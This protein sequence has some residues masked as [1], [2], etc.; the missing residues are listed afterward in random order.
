MILAIFALSQVVVTGYA[1]Q[2]S[3]AQL[4][5]GGSSAFLLVELAGPMG[6]PFPLAP[7]LSALG[8]AALGV[9][10]GLPA[11]RLQ[12]IS[13]AAVT[14]A[15]AAA[16]EM[17]WFNNPD[18]NG[19]LSGQ[20]VPQPTLF[21]IDLGIGSGLAYPRPAFG[22]LVLGVL[23]LVA[24]AVAMLRRS[25]LGAAMLAVRANERS[26]AASGINVA[27]T[28][29]TAFALGSFIAGLGGAMLAYQQQAATAA[30]FTAL[31]GVALFAAVYLAGVSSVLGG[32]AAGV[33]AAGG[34]AS[35]TIAQ[36]VELDQYFAVLSGL[37]LV[38]T[39]IQ[40]PEG[41]T[42]PIQDLLHR[43]RMR[44][45]NDV[46]AV[47]GHEVTA[48]PDAP[49]HRS[50]PAGAIVLEV[51]N[52][53]VTYGGV[54][55]VDDVSFVARRGEILGIIGP[56]GAGKT[57]LLDAIS[58]FVPRATGSVVLNG[59]DLTG[60]RPHQRVRRGL[61]RT[62]QSIELYDDLTVEENVRVGTMGTGT[63]NAAG[64][65]GLQQI[66]AALDLAN[67]RNRP[68]SELSQGQRQLVSVA[69]A[70][71]GRP[72]VLLLDEP[73]AGLDSHESA[74]L[75]MRLEAIRE[76]GTS[77]VMIDHDMGL[78][79]KTCD[80]VVVLDRGRKIAD[81]PPEEIR[82]DPAVIAAYLGAV[83]AADD[84]PDGRTPGAA[85]LTGEVQS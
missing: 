6:V 59:S 81:G 53:R 19:G 2:V 42:G 25:R 1:G 47:D 32:L 54:T 23:S 52:V 12:G 40:F 38:V 60:L 74:W 39:V 78:V 72:E 67:V 8:A 3:L 64:R 44:R 50:D 33:L 31:G 18:L 61:G 10:I 30:S 26:A 82:Q 73:A 35:F 84:A 14:L 34:I 65:D 21:G 16:A 71:A 29:I 9:V 62:F 49:A 77:I 56:N 15:F 79:L 70:L 36:W 83:H 55:A 76:A 66:F 11:L 63:R 24:L 57:T 48:R 75:G 20:T 7:L 5:I 17:F 46:P 68:V 45:R 22:L 80:R 69:R 13:V 37:L 51:E 58:G 27:R 43:V 85:V 41:M 28:K 4:T